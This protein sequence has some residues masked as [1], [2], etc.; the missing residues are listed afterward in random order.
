MS[1]ASKLP[2]EEFAR[3]GFQ[4]GW[5]AACKMI[6]DEME[7]A[8]A[9]PANIEAIRK[10]SER[11]P[12]LEVVGMKAGETTEEAIDRSD[13]PPTARDI[14]LSLTDLMSV[15]MDAAKTPEAH[16]QVTIMQ[17]GA[18]WA[19]AEFCLRCAQSDGVSD[20]VAT[21]KEECLSFIESNSAASDMMSKGTIQ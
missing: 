6:T 5:F 13:S 9:N 11:V 8:G 14:L 21:V 10:W 17:W 7:K 3:A 16:R 18:I 12:E 2:P 15:G 20:S 19:L 1:I 4:A